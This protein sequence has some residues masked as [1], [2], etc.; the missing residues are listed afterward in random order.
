MISVVIRT[1][2][3][4]KN[5][6]KLLQIL[7]TQTVE[8]EVIVVDSGSTDDTIDVAKKYGCVI[9]KCIPFTYGKALN[10]SLIHI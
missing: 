9:E 10:L 8:H 6:D 2:N 1:L 4:G 7:K 3:E 5:L